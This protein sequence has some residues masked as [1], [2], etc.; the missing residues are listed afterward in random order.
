MNKVYKWIQ[1]GKTPPY[2]RVGSS[3]YFRA[4]DVLVH[5]GAGAFCASECGRIYRRDAFKRVDSPPPGVNQQ[6]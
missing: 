5:D 6:P 2:Y 4:S 3:I 1:T